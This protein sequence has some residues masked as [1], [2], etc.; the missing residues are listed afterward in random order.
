MKK[1]IKKIV[2]KVKEVISPEPVAPV[3]TEAPELIAR[4]EVKRN[5]G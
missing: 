1:E 3:S 4:R 2:K 5:Q